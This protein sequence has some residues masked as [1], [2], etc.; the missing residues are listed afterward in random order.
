MLSITEPSDFRGGLYL[1]PKGLESRR[2]FD[3]DV[4]DLLL[5]RFDLPHGVDVLSGR[6]FSVIFWF[7]DCEESVRQGTTPWYDR[8]EGSD[9]CYNLGVQHELGLHGK[10]INLAKAK[11]FYRRAAEAGHA[12]AQNNLGLLEPSEAEKWLRRAAERGHATAQMN[13]AMWLLERDACDAGEA[14][15][16]MRSAAESEPQ[17]AFYLG[18]M[19]RRGLGVAEDLREAQRWWRLSAARGFHKAYVEL[20]RLRFEEGAYGEAAQ[21]FA[22]AVNDP[23]AGERKVDGHPMLFIDFHAFS[24][25]F[26]WI[27]NRCSF[28]FPLRW[29]S[30]QL[31]RPWRCW[32]SAGAW[33]SESRRCR[34][35]SAWRRRGTRRW[36]TPSFQAIFGMFSHRFH[37]FFM[38]FQGIIE[39]FHTFFMVFKPLAGLW[40][41]GALPAGAL[42]REGLAS[43]GGHG[44][45]G[46]GEGRGEGPRR[47]PGAAGGVAKLAGSKGLRRKSVEQVVSCSVIYNILLLYI[48]ICYYIYYYYI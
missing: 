48:Y 14:W 3:V 39:D 20:G 42:L 12:F 29:G 28:D 36:T 46:A 24:L 7:K 25:T 13:L 40:K 34:S 18:D 22:K 30:Q 6:R 16:L 23:E 5:H 44:H 45:R 32:C 10:S 15:R 4:G 8:E 47:G 19:Q 2:Y 26:P 17:A 33:P 43:G 35:G 9:A 11:S 37:G 38:F 27:L 41:T 21:L 1:Q 31:G